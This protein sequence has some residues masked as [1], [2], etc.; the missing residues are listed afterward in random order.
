MCDL[1]SAGRTGHVPK[2]ARLCV[3]V[4]PDGLKWAGEGRAL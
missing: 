4:R 2:C 3:C 1:V